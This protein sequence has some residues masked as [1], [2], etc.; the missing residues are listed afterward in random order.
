MIHFLFMRIFS[1]FL[2]KMTSEVWSMNV[3]GENSTG[4]KNRPETVNLRELKFGIILE[5]TIALLIQLL[6]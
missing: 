5:S 1:T 3:N 6:H 4:N 2:T